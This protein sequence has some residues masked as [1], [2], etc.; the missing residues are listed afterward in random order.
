M[1]MYLEGQTQ[2]RIAEAMGVSQPAVSKIIRRMEDRLL[3][4]VSVKV[5]RHRARHTMRLEF[6]Y[7]EAVRAWQGSKE[8]GVRRRQRKSEGGAGREGGSIAEIVSE[9]RHGDP[10]YLESARRALE[11]LRRL[12]GVDPPERLAVNDATRFAHL[13]DAA[14][15]G[16]IARLVT[17]ARTSSAQPSAEGSGAQSLPGGTNHGQ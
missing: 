2:H 1:E 15:E 17:L 4:D 16:E 9:S 6:I 8:D 12:W 14:L 5:E 3:A 10:R 13:S 11:D 7:G